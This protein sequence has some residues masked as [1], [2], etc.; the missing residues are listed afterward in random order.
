[1]KSS[2]HLDSLNLTLRGIPPGTATAAVRDL[3]PALAR[4]LSA[5]GQKSAATGTLAVSRHVSAQALR[6]AIATHVAGAIQ[7]HLGSKR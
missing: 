2:L 6:G 4:A 3:G 5:A 7:P 1:M